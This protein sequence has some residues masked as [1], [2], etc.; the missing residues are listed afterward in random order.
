MYSALFHFYHLFET[1]KG[2]AAVIKL[3][4][5]GGGLYAV[6]PIDTYPGLSVQAVADSS[7]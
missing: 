2:K 3:E 7:R 4:E 1:S 6:C 5:N